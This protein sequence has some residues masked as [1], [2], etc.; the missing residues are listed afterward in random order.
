MIAPRLR[1]FSPPRPLVGGPSCGTGH[2][3][4]AGREIV[5]RSLADKSSGKDDRADYSHQW[6]SIFLV[7]EGV[8]ERSGSTWSEPMGEWIFSG[9]MYLFAKCFSR[10][11][12]DFVSGDYLLKG[13]R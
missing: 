5:A 3:S 9:F 13:I 4:L 11:L 1:G 2:S 12:F 7:E 8:A 6:T 10:Q